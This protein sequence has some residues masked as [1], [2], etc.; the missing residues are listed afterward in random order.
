MAMTYLM[1]SLV[2]R[3]MVQTHLD[4]AVGIFSSTAVFLPQCKPNANYIF[5]GEASLDYF[6]DNVSVGDL[7]EMV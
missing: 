4:M 1:W 5:E 7:D 3:S 2:P 6:G